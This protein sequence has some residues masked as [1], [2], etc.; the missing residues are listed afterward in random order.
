MALSEV[1]VSGLDYLA[2][3]TSLLQRARLSD[4]EAGEWEAADLQW[5]WRTPRPSDALRQHFWLDDKGPVAGVV[6][7]D[8][9]RTWECVPVVVTS[10]PSIPLAVVWERAVEAIDSLGLDAVEVLAR[11]DDIE[12]LEILARAG[13]MR[14]ENQYG[15]TWMNAR[16]RPA[17]ATVPDG[18]ALV[19][20]EQATGPHPMRRRNGEGVEARLR[21]CSLYDPGLDL[22][23]G[24]SDGCVAGYALFWFD[25]VTKVGLVE[26]M[27]VEDR[28]Q[29]RGLARALL[30]EGLDRLAKRGARRLKVGYGTEAA[31][32]LYTGAGFRV[33]ATCRSYRRS[34]GRRPA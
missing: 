34:R 14:D 19:D 26:P 3:A 8:W 15:L 29:R 28:Y 33:S 32:R 27:R 16:D 1:E 24:G 5:W 9:G 4:A 11:D 25:P 6:L 13:F 2:L 18:Y 22:A 7:T 10:P 17:V 31:R 23:I 20:R 12:L 30:T 21:Q